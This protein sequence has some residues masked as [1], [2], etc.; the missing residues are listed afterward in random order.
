MQL[1]LTPQARLTD[2]LESHDAAESVTKGTV[3]KSHRAVLD[4]L[5]HRN[6]MAWE[7]EQ[8]LSHLPLSES[9]I[10]SAFA[11]LERLGKIKVVGEGKTSFGRRARVW[12][13]V[14][15]GV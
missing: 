9:R 4:L 5:R 8:E 11:E 14:G 6:L 1:T 2:P 7:A 3:A 15:S 10:R 12:G 13:Y